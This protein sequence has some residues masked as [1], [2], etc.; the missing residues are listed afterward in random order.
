MTRNSDF[1]DTVA[2]FRLEGLELAEQE[3]R[4][5]REV[6]QLPYSEEQICAFLKGI[7]YITPC[8]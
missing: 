4:V 2:I 5:L 8:K 6:N 3:I 1:E 7:I